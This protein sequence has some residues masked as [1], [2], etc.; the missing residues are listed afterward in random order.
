[1]VLQAREQAP[2]GGSQAAPAAPRLAVAAEGAPDVGT[3]EPRP[4]RATPSPGRKGAAGRK[5]PRAEPRGAWPPGCAGRG[6]TWTTHLLAFA[7]ALALEPYNTP[8]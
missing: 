7:A 6:R 3:G 1:M 4:E 8:L 5:R 2:G